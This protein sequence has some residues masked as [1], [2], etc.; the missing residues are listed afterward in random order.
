[1]FAHKLSALAALV[2]AVLAAQAPAFAPAA[3]VPTAASNNYT[4][5]SNGTLSNSPVVSGKAFDR[6]IQIWLENTDYD[7]AAN[8]S[9]FMALK[10]QGILLSNY[11][12]VTH[13]SE[14]NY[15][16]VVGGDFWA[17]GDDNYYQIPSN[18][19]TVV[20]LLEAK[21]ISWAAYME[22][23]PTDGYQGFNYT[24]ANYLNSSA[25]PYT[26]YVRKHNPTILYD[27]VTTVPSRLARHRNFNDFAADVNASA[28][29]QWSFITPNMEDDG[30]DSSIDFASDWLQF[31][32]TPLLTDPNFNNDKTLIVLTFD[33]NDSYNINN[34]I[35]TLLL[36]NAVPTNLHNTT[37]PTFYTHFSAL[38]TVQANWALGSLGR[39]DTNKTVSNVFAFVANAT[40]YQ[41][42]DVAEADIPLTNLT[43]V[44]NGPLN[45][46]QYVPFLA[47]NMSAVGAGGGPVFVASNL[48]QSLTTANAP[49]PVNLTALNETVPSEVTTTAS[50]PGPSGSG[51]GSGSGAVHVSA[52]GTASAIAFAGV[53]AAL[54]MTL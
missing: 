33:E 10:E 4:G 2:P 14:P 39:Q 34:R 11:Y 53:L 41:N 21:N 42:L 25:P 51:S 13:P 46:N 27:S 19:S 5:V 49:A 48:D 6:F 22:N 38:S 20:D 1:M 37:D 3:V 24:S 52:M 17:M 26:F 30:H 45:P 35:Y 44:Y 43:G 32:L 54:C 36:G 18:I 28:I 8:T 9:A 12:A 40:G 23:L 16:A 29:P 31:W 15:A 47:P 50:A 7:D